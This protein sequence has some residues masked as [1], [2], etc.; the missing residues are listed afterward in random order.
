MVQEG[1]GAELVGDR[2][3]ESDQPSQHSAAQHSTIE[4]LIPFRTLQT[5][6]VS[7]VP[8]TTIQYTVQYS[9]SWNINARQSKAVRYV[10]TRYDAIQQCKAMLQYTSNARQH[11]AMQ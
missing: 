1:E 3:D 2:E 4:M 9:D 8:D 6:V 11:C 7:T 10:A 5:T